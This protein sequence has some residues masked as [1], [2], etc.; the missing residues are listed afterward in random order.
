MSAATVESGADFRRWPYKK[1]KA[2]VMRRLAEMLDQ[3]V[4]NIDWSKVTFAPDQEH[5]ILSE[6]DLQSKK[7]ESK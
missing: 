2:W 4:D 7:G 3:G 1:R 5:A 6:F